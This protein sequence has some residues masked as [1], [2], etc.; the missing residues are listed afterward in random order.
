MTHK[1]LTFAPKTM[2]L[3]ERGDPYRYAFWC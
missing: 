3:I 1:Q 2:V